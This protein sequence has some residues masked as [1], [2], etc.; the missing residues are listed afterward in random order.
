MV[1]S[2]ERTEALENE[3]IN[4][5]PKSGKPKASPNS[6]NPPAQAGGSS[7]FGGHFS[8]NFGGGLSFAPPAAIQLTSFSRQLPAC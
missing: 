4:K 6:G 7:A 3:N 5:E 2:V 8:T 1:N